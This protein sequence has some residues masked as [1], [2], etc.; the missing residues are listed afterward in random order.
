[1]CISIQ[2][3]MNRSVFLLRGVRPLSVLPGTELRR[4]SLTEHVITQKELYGSLFL[5][6]S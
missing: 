6:I 2:Y 5:K 4:V 1:M 3:L